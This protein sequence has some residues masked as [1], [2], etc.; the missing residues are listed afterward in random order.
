MLFLILS[1]ADVDFLDRELRWRTYTT[2]EAFLTTKRVELVGKKEF[3]A[4]ALDPENET[5]VVHI[6]S[7][8][9]DASLSSSPLELNIHPTR[10][11]QIA[12]LI[13]KKALTK[14][15]VKYVDFADIFCPDLAFE[16]PEYTSLT[17]QVACQHSNIFYPQ[18]RR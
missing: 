13:A 6:G 2:K 14:I 10:R 5:Y 15:L 11:S 7:V 16:L 9:S 3:A 12:G 18:E 4:A 8:N 17:F 1:G